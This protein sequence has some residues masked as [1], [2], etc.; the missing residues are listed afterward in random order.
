M[1]SITGYL[2]NRPF[3]RTPKVV[4][5]FGLIKKRM[6]STPVLRHPHFSMVFEVASNASGYRIRGVL[7][8]EGHPIT[9]FF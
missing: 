7:S 8:Q 4:L 3:A 1:A 2:K 6:S 5:A 9:L